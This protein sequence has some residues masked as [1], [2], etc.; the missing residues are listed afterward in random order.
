MTL[1]K[2][3]LARVPARP[4]P[5]QSKRS[6]AQTVVRK[7]QQ[8]DSW[9]PSIHTTRAEAR[10]CICGESRPRLSVERSSTLLRE[11]ENVQPPARN[12]LL[13]QEFTRNEANRC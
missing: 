1:T 7:T 6:T 11:W 13:L 3:R 9:H 2:K 4:W 10:R 12:P 5:A 8:S